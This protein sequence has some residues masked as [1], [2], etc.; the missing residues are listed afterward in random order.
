MSGQHTPGPW[1]SGFDDLEGVVSVASVGMVGDGNVVC[2]PPRCGMEA[3]YARWPANARLIAAAPDLYEALALFEKQWNACG[4]NSDFG[5][6]F[7]RVR[8]VAVKALAKADPEHWT[9]KS[10]RA[11][12]ILAAAPGE[13]A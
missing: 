4:P 11:S 10:A 12:D 5:R 2:L 3:S 13:R 8:D 7:Q 6:H 9:N 1:Q